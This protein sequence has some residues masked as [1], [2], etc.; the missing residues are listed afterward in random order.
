MRRCS[1]NNRPKRNS[2]GRTDIERNVFFFER[3]KK[4]RN[5]TEFE[6]KHYMPHRL[7]DRQKLANELY[8]DVFTN[9]QLNMNLR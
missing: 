8:F 4:R 7:I 3:E 5:K 6:L 1:V 9:F 2:V